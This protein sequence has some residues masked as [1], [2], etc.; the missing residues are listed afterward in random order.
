MRDLVQMFEERGGSGVCHAGRSVGGRWVSILL[1]HAGLDACSSTWIAHGWPGLAWPVSCHV[2][3][4]RPVCPILWRLGGR[5]YLWVLSGCLRSEGE[6][7]WWWEGIW[8][9]EEPGRGREGGI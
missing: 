3:E 8:G 1:V 7:G 2:V 6:E 9:Y 5:G 4:L